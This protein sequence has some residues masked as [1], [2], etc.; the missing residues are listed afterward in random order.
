M[1]VETANFLHNRWYVAALSTEVTDAPLARTLLN[2]QMVLYRDTKGAAI[3]LEDRCVH[4]QAPLSLGE[5]IGDHL[6]CGY[7]GFTYDRTGACVRVPSQARIPPG[8]CVRAYPV[9]EQQGFVHV[10]PGDPARAEGQTPFDFP[11][12]DNDGWNSRYASLRGNFDYRL[13]IDNL[14]DLTHLAFT[15]KKTIGAGGVAEQGRT[16]TERDGDLVRVIRLMDNIAPAPVHVEVTG[17]EGNVDRWQ[18]IEFNPPCHIALDVGNAKAGKGG[19][20]AAARDKLIDRRTLHI[21]TP[22]TKTT[23]LYFWASTYPSDAMNT[24]QEKII[25]DRTMEVLDEDITMI[26]GQQSRLNGAV[27]IVDINEDAGQI[28]MRQTLARLIFE[29]S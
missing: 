7:H 2:E 16:S 10:W 1:T 18:I 3:V 15:H 22:E 28:A 20:D 24:E 6:Q 25:Y 11:F 14:M 13:L 27:P 5:V 23:T 29:E 9:I 21:A 8:A 4:R 12:V 19:H 26:E 17:Y